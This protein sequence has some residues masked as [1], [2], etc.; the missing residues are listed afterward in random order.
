MRRKYI[1][2]RGEAGHYLGLPK[3]TRI[4]LSPL[5]SDVIAADF[6]LEGVSPEDLDGKT[7]VI[8]MKL[9]KVSEAKTSVLRREDLTEE[10]WTKIR[11]Q[12]FTVP[13]RDQYD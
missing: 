11:Q 7:I 6:Q 13:Y 8:D 12:G 3:T 4:V 10:E 9:S 5:G 2:F 1:R